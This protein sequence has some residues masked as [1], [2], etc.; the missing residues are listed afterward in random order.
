MARFVQPSVAFV[1]YLRGETIFNHP[2]N[3]DLC[4]Q[5]RRSRERWYPDNKGKPSIVFEGCDAKWVYDS[6]K[7]RDADYEHLLSFNN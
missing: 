5:V 7:E 2:V 6:D 3:V 4:T 1:S